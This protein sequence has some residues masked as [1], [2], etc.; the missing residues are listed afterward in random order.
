MITASFYF[1]QYSLYVSRIWHI[2]LT[3]WLASY[4]TDYL[5]T[6]DEWKMYTISF[7]LKTTSMS[8]WVN[9]ESCLHC[10]AQVMPQ[11]NHKN[12]QFAID[13]LLSCHWFQCLQFFFSPQKQKKIFA[14]LLSSYYVLT[15]H[16]FPC[17]AL[18]LTT[19]IIKIIL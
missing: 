9:I 5:T 19:T 3:Y 10:N 17:H 6:L 14:Q 15:L 12:S 16:Y 4:S 7:V 18:R 1:I 13:F 8:V 11:K 2:W